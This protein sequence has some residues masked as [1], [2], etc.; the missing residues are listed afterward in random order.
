MTVLIIEDTGRFKTRISQIKK[1]P[2]GEPVG[3]GC[4]DVSD[5]ERIIAIFPVGYADGLN[6]K[7]GNGT[8]TVYKWMG[9]NNRKYLHGYVHG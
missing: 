5:N 3:Y 9:S 8:E 6:R 4:A 1:I 2:A 7:L